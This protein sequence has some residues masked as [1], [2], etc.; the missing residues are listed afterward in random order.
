MEEQLFKEIEQFLHSQPP[1]VHLIASSDR[2][3]ISR[4][5]SVL[6]V[7]DKHLQITQFMPII[8]DIGDNS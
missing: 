5:G 4:A 8:G 1:E 6:I 3:I 2:F 7:E